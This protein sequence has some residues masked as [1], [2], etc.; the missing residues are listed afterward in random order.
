MPESSKRKKPAARGK[1]ANVLRIVSGQRFHAHGC[2]G[3]TEA[4]RHSKP[5]E[6]VMP[7]Y[8]IE[9]EIPKAGNL[10]PGEL[11][12]IS[13]K[14]CGI[15]RDLGPQIQWVQS[16]VT[17]DKIYCVYIAPDEELVRQHARQGGFP[18]DSVFEVRTI[19]DPTT[20]E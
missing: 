7:K 8:I 11:Q 18:A 6:S 5:K 17:A 3:G 1:E 19:I 16:Y 10:S 2:H 4:G 13:R 20:A 15:L 12:S 9:R 14:S